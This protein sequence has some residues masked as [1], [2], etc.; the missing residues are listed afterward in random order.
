MW[1]PRRQFEALEK[2]VQQLEQ[3]LSHRPSER[4]FQPGAAA[5]P[6]LEGGAGVDPAGLRAIGPDLDL[7]RAEL[8][9]GHKIEAIRLYRQQTNAGLKEAKDAVEALERMA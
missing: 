6:T 7:I 9:R 8:A 1:V 5:W 2:R 4:G 3:A